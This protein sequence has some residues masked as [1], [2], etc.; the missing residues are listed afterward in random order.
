MLPF[1]S[2]LEDSG[3]SPHVPEVSELRPSVER[4]ETTQGSNYSSALVP[5]DQQSTLRE[6]LQSPGKEQTHSSR[7]SSQSKER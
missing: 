2:W 6:L 5:G 4:G 1:S 3:A 7:M